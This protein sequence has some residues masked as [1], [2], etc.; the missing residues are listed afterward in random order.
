VVIGQGAR[1]WS[2]PS[3]LAPLS[4]LCRLNIFQL[5]AE[6]RAAG[7][8]QLHVHWRQF[9]LGGDRLW[10]WFGGGGGRHRG[11]YPNACLQHAVIGAPGFPQGYNATD[12][13]IPAT[14][15]QNG[16]ARYL[17]LRGARRPIAT[18]TSLAT[19]TTWLYQAIAAYLPWPPEYVPL[20]GQ[21]P[22]AKIYPVKVF[23]IDADS[24]FSIVLNGLDHVLSLKRDG[25]LDI[26][27][28]NMSL[29]WPS[30]YAEHDIFEANGQPAE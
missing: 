14:D 9:D 22:L 7:L 3:K 19:R 12:D 13:G 28:V 20:L 26:D 29:G 18:W 8:R 30:L 2:F 15:I 27:I 6:H 4:G 10:S 1:R 16:S 11:C 24:S 5:K 17:G 21:A 25:L 23:P